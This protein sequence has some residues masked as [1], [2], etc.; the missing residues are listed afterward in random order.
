MSLAKVGLDAGSVRG[1]LMEGIAGQA[2][3]DSKHKLQP[4]SR[5]DSEF[6]AALANPNQTPLSK[7]ITDDGVLL[8]RGECVD[9]PHPLEPMGCGQLLA[10]L[11]KC[12]GVQRLEGIHDAKLCRASQEKTSVA[13]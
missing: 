7:Y 12:E 8:A 4:S 10:I 2:N 3:D 5:E 1:I 13:T 6:H 11:A 9:R